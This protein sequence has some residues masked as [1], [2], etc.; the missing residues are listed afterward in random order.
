MRRWGDGEDGE[1]GGIGAPSGVGGQWG[2]LGP[3]LGLGGNGGRNQYKFIS[4]GIV[5]LIIAAIATE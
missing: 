3:P 1:M 4:V 5:Y 2:A